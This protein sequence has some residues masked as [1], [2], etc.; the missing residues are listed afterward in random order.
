VADCAPVALVAG[1]AIAAVHVGWRGLLA[2]IIPATVEVIRTRGRGGVRAVIGPCISA[3][4][5]EFGARE[6][7]HVAQRVGMEVRARTAD[8]AP[9]LDLRAGVRAALDGAGVDERT[10]IDVC[11][12]TSD[13]HFSHRRDGV[14]G[15][16]ALIVTRE[17]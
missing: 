9:A 17:R 11:T 3:T 7:D 8:G 5:Y 14:T 4:H 1:D 15:R 2:G 10:D 16:Q 12:F 13:V 6:L